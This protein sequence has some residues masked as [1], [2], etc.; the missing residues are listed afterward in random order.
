MNDPADSH[1]EWD[2][3]KALMDKT[4]TPHFDFRSRFDS[5]GKKLFEGNQKLSLKDFQ[6]LSTTLESE[7]NLPYKDYIKQIEAYVATTLALDCKLKG[8]SK[9]LMTEIQTVQTTTK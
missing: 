3:C 9:K 6:T 7:V 2:K 8:L 1:K 4:Q 5:S